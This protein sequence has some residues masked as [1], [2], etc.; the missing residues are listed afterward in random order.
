[1]QPA[2]RRP[3]PLAE[4][5]RQSHRPR[6]Y[7]REECPRNAFRESNPGV[8]FHLFSILPPAIPSMLHRDVSALRQGIIVT[9]P[10]IREGS[11][12]STEVEHVAQ[13]ML[14]QS[15]AADH[16]SITEKSQGLRTNFLQWLNEIDELTT[17][18]RRNHS[19]YSRGLWHP[20]PTLDAREGGVGWWRSAAIS[21]VPAQPGNAALALRPCGGS[22]LFLAGI[23]SPKCILTGLA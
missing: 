5:L 7:L 14:R 4:P 16:T 12:Y 20:Q 13:K 10:I 23:I 6:V 9:N 3:F 15:K 11:L 22:L 19:T 1:M 18:T 8:G 17:P 2:R 21:W